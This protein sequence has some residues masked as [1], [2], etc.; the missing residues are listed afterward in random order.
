MAAA[1]LGAPLRRGVGVDPICKLPRG[2]PPSSPAPQAPQAPQ[3]PAPAADPAPQNDDP[4]ENDG[5]LLPPGL[6]PAFAAD[7]PFPALLFCIATILYYVSQYARM[8][9]LE[10][11]VVIVNILLV[12]AM[13]PN[14]IN[15]GA[16][17]LDK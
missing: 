15:L 3:Q 2:P 12:I 14:K 9:V 10:A 1:A 6:W 16:A 4:D 13:P 5:L 8:P 7:D 17:A 11:L